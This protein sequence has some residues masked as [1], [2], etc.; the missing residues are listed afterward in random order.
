MTGERVSE[1]LNKLKIKNCKGYGRIPM[2]ILKDGASILINLLL[3]LFGR[4]YVKRTFQKQWKVAKIIPLH[5]KG[6]KHEVANY[7]PISNLCFVTKVFEKLIQEW[8]EKIGEKKQY[9]P[10]RKATTQ[11]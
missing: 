1:C 11:F 6:N 9:R 3:A 4:I 8:L 5:K 10:H 2:R 7:R